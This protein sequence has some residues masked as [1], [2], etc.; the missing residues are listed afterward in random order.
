MPLLID[1]NNLMHALRGAGADV[2][3]EGLC[4]LL[5]AFAGGRQRVRVVFDGPAP[6]AGLAEQIDRD[7]IAVEYAGR[8]SADDVLIDAIA[9]DT[10]PRRLTVVSTDRV[11][12]RA[13]RRRRCTIARSEDFAETLLRALEDRPPRRP[14][15]P[16]EKRRGLTPEQ[17]RAWLKEFGLDGE[18]TPE[19]PT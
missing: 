16:A 14:A 8:S 18:P 15:E 11:I 10:A 5:A 7:G 12:R 6:P 4:R 9:A 19:D 3:R 1:G 17:S 13:G 2:G